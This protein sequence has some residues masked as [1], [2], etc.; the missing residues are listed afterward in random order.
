[1]MTAIHDTVDS[2]GVQER[3]W[4]VGNRGTGQPRFYAGLIPRFDLVVTHFYQTALIYFAVNRG[5]Y[6][7]T[8]PALYVTAVE[9]K[10]PR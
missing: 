2:G 10:T 9:G 4:L 6:K 5:F 8:A 7:D 3:G 1:M